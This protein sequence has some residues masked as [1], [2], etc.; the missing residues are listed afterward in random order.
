M[1]IF[2]VTVSAAEHTHYICGK[3]QCTESSH[4]NLN[5]S[6]WSSGNSLPDKGGQ[7]YLTSDVYLETEWSVPTGRTVLCLNGHDIVLAGPSGH[8]I[9]IPENGNLQLQTVQ[10]T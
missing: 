7:Y 3:N 8:V 1:I 6:P 9:M 10:K 2:G 5:Y 4:G